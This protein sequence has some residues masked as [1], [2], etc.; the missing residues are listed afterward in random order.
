MRVHNNMFICGSALTC[1]NFRAIINDD[2]CAITIEKAD[3]HHTFSAWQARQL[4]EWLLKTL[5]DR[6]KVEAERHLGVDLRERLK[7]R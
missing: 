6:D 5:P 3:G 4:A 2:G 1:G 7:D